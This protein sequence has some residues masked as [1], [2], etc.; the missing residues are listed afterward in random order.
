MR[1]ALAQIVSTP[2]PGHNLGLVEEQV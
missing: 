2:D 1:I